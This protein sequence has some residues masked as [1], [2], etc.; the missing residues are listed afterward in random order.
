VA[1]LWD[2]ES[3]VGRG[4]VEELEL[5]ASRLCGKRVQIVNS[6]F[7]GGGVAEIL[8]RMVPLLNQLGIEAKWD[9]IEGDEE[10]FKVTKKF[11]NALQGRDERISPRD[12]FI[13]GETSQRNLEHV[14]LYGD[15]MFINDPQPIA[16]I[17][18]K[19]EIGRKWLW[20]C[21]IDVS[22]PNPVVWDFL[23]GF[24]DD[25]DGAVFSAPQFAQPLPIR[26]F[27]IFPSIDPLSDKNKELSETEIQRVLT[28]YGITSEKPIITQISRFDHFKD[29]LGVIDAFNMV[30]KRT[31]CQLI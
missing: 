11:H 17:A 24:I 25:Y 12:F 8:S 19:K 30:R 15:V 3:I 26:Q 14:E 4:P 20:R 7:T 16:L 1:E 5:L 28:K 21:H 13:F 10:F 22:K 23:C 9:V 18:K 31:D 6:T 29:P 2:Y 27:L